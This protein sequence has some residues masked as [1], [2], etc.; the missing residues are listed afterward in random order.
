MFSRRESM[1]YKLPLFTKSPEQLML[2]PRV[3]GEH[4]AGTISPR[5]GLCSRTDGRAQLPL[6]GLVPVVGP[7]WAPIP[8]SHPE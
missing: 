4:R 3:S 5:S 7:G 8:S 6:E 1:F 2:H